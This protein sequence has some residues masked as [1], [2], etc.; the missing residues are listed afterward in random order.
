MREK[1]GR[2][3]ERMRRGSEGWDISRMVISRP[4]QHCEPGVCLIVTLIVCQCAISI[5]LFCLSTDRSSHKE[6]VEIMKHISEDEYPP[7]T[8]EKPRYDQVSCTAE[9][10]SAA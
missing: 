5:C 1:G 2:G 4:W 3:R 8:L 7:F 10:I 6:A 9:T